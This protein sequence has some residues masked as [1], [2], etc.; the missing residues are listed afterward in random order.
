MAGTNRN[1]ATFN[2]GIAKAKATLKKSMLNAG[3]LTAEELVRTAV[4]AY[5]GDETSPTGES[6]NSLTG[7]LVNSIMGG[8]YYNKFLECICTA[9]KSAGIPAAT[10]TYTRIGDGGFM[11]YDSG[12]FLADVI[13]SDVFTTGEEN[14]S[15]TTITATFDKFYN[16]DDLYE[17]NPDAGAQYKGYAMVP[18]SISIDGDYKS[19]YYT[20]FEYVTGLEDP[21]KYPDAMLYETLVYYGVYYAES[22]NFRAPWN[23]AVVIAAMAIDNEGR[24]SRVYRQKYTFRKYNASPIS[25]LLSKAPQ[26]GADVKIPYA[27]PEFNVELKKDKPAGDNRYSAENMEKV[28]RENRL[29]KF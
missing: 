25:D 14:Y 2:A 24:Y 18:V 23:K 9:S 21:E 22:V 10:H 12:E 29:R 16:G 11:D 8:V 5:R 26:T 3:E 13:F 6:Q 17:L 27:L 28:R 1:I 15:P 7:N 19:Y 20:I 4:E